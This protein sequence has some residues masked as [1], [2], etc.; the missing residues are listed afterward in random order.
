[1]G[2]LQRIKSLFRR[3]KKVEPS[4]SSVTIGTPPI[5]EGTDKES[6]EIRSLIEEHKLLE[7]ERI[8]LRKE[9]DV[10]EMRFNSGIIA[11]ADRDTAY[12][13][14]LSRAGQISLRQV[15][16]R[17]RLIELEYPVPPEWRRALRIA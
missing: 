10:I 16:I 2:L 6:T 1:M 14:R 5:P 12:R 13:L 9:I 7:E 3:K 15:E 8:R 11:A 17:N 4:S